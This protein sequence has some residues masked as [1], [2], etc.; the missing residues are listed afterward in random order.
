MRKPWRGVGLAILFGILLCSALA[1]TWVNFAQSKEAQAKKDQVS[2]QASPSPADAKTLV[3]AS[4]KDSPQLAYAGEWLEDFDQ[5]KLIA[6]QRKRPL[7]LDFTGSDWCGW[8][9][10]LHN[11]VF[12][13][14]EFKDYATKGLVLVKLDFPR[15]RALPAKIK[16]QNEKLAREYGIQGFPT[17]I[18]LDSAGK[19][20][21][22]MGYI[23]GGP[24]AFLG[25]LKEIAE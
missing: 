24:A 3:A 1:A 4:Q 9:I 7:L 10:K 25:K 23:P 13:K 12:D 5:A 15:R 14:K 19:R 6:A 21:G 2:Y 22:Q 11:E 20:I 18:V 8:C 16:R 17:I